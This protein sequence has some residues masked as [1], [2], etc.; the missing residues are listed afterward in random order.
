MSGLRYHW[1]EWLLQWQSHLG[2]LWLPG[3]HCYDRAWFVSCVTTVVGRLK[4]VYGYQLAMVMI[5]LGLWAVSQPSFECLRG[6]IVTRLQCHDKV[7]YAG[8]VTSRVKMWAGFPRLWCCS[9]VWFPWE[10]KWMGRPQDVISPMD[11][12]M[13]GFKAWF[14][15]RLVC[16]YVWVFILWAHF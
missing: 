14:V 15:I 1:C 5:E 6:F 12:W 4:G 3:F 9:V 16:E 8:Y 11:G 10:Q 13:D 7:W 2:L